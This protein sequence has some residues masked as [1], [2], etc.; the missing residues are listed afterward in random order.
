M[1]FLFFIFFF[2]NEIGQQ[3]FSS[4]TRQIWFDE[5]GITIG[6]RFIYLCFLF[7]F[8]FFIFCLC[9][10]APV[11]KQNLGYYRGFGHLTQLIVVLAGHVVIQDQ[12]QGI[13]FFFLFCFFHFV[14]FLYFFSFSFF[15]VSV[16]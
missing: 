13:L 1:L 14:S 4:A 16:A 6:T 9:F 3:Q 2:L 10:F 12:T 5:H 15:D 11:L 8:L 7:L